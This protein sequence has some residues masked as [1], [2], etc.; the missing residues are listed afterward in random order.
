MPPRPALHFTPRAHWMNDPNG[1][2]LHDGT[3]HLFFQHNPSGTRWG[4]M[5]WGHATSR[6]LV[7]WEE[8]PLAIPGTPTE[9]IFSGSVVHDVGRTS[10][11]GVAGTA[12]L[13]AIH[14]SAWTP[15]HPTRAGTQSQSVAHSLD[16]GLTWTP[17]PGNPV[18]DRASADFRDPKVFRY[19]GPAGGWWVMVAVEAVLQQVVLHR[20]D[21]LLHWTFLS[22]FDNAHDRAVVWECPDLFELPVDGDPGRTK[23]V[24]VVS[25]NPGGIAGGSGTQYF[26]GD[27]DGTT[28]TAEH[29]D[30]LDHGRDH[31]AAVSFHGVPGGR[32]VMMGWMSNWEYAEDVPAGA[33]RG[34]MTL[35][36]EVGL[37]TTPGGPR[38]RQRVVDELAAVR[39][40]ATELGSRSVSD[41]VVA[42]PARGDVVQ[43]DVVLRPGDAEA[44]G[45][46]VLGDALHATTIGY[47]AVGGAVVVDRTRSGDV[48]FHASFAS[49]ERA[50]VPLR[51]GLVSFRVYVDRSSVEVFADDG[52]VTITSQV[53]PPAGADGIGVW[54]RGGT[55][56]FESLTLTPLGDPDPR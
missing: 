3:W 27:F 12:P 39:G 7:H 16:G 40:P 4:N 56:T 26:V 11:L 51:D 10:G 28:F 20:S 15:A 42:L 44:A 47:D 1:L 48:D 50:S 46:S 43:V 52:L 21:D 31:Y 33:W 32:R 29:R 14:T 24:L 37:V 9:A 35:P 5:S 30:W 6:D 17:Y 13:V 25:L 53:V 55:A 22:T 45:I 19:D 38:L 34:S 18:L 41:D 49:A 23:W 2:V 54:S 8:Q 36:R